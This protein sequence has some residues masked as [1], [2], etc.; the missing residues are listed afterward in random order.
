[1]L[2]LGAI[3]GAFFPRLLILVF[4]I[5]TNLVDRAFTGFLVPLLG[6]LF[7]PYTTLSYVAAYSPIADGLV[8]ASW[9]WVVLGFLV[10]LMA[11]G[12]GRFG[13]T[14]HKPHQPHPV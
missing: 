2:I 9:L 4:W 5:T 11:Y 6:T 3:L 8:G 10:D 13:M 1:M 14:H 12:Y 7:L